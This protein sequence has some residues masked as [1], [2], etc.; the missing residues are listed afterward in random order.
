M[1]AAPSAAELRAEVGG[2]DLLEVIEFA[3]GGIAHCAGNV[4]LE[5]ENGHRKSYH[6]ATEALSTSIIHFVFLS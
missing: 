1:I 2:L 4:D 6:G 5:S 3:P